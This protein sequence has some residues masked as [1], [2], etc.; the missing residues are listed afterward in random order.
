MTLPQ[1]NKLANLLEERQ[2]CL[3]L[4]TDCND[5]PPETSTAVGST[6]PD[7]NVC[8]R[9]APWESSDT[10]PAPAKRKQELEPQRRRPG[11]Q[12]RSRSSERNVRM[13]RPR[14]DGHF[15]DG[16]KKARRRLGVQLG[17]SVDHVQ[18]GLGIFRT[19]TRNAVLR[20]SAHAGSR[21]GIASVRFRH[22][23][24]RWP[25]CAPDGL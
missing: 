2:P 23:S 20:N 14:R 21:T 22:S 10:G 16:W 13:L 5:G 4:S 19:F 3:T 11:L 6:R 9:W 12:R 1:P 17:C 15:T 25:G 18:M 8:V 24:V 7:S